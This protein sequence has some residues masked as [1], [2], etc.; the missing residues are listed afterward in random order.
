MAFMKKGC[1][2]GLWVFILS[3]I[4]VIVVELTIL[5][6]VNP[7]RKSPDGIRDYIL[8]LTPIAMSKEDAFEIISNKNDW[9][10]VFER[11][12]GV[13]FHRTQISGWPTTPGGGS[14]V[15]ETSIQASLGTYR[16]L[17]GFLIERY[18]RVQWAFDKD[19]KLVDVYVQKLLSL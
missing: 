2:I 13:L 18:V 10:R 3:L 12:Q 5:A 19:G 6:N 7:I 16:A 8:S 1:S 15:G 4:L 9:S 11:E 17:S 14:I